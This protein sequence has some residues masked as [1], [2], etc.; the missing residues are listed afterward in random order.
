MGT[1]ALARGL[2]E[3]QQPLSVLHFLT[4]LHTKNAILFFNHAHGGSCQGGCTSCPCRCWESHIRMGDGEL[5]TLSTILPC[6]N[7]REATPSYLK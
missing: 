4:L 3:N 6:V 2:P 5:G 1:P 7:G